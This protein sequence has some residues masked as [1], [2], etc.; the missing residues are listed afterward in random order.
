MIT[1]AKKKDKNKKIN[2]ITNDLRKYVSKK[3]FD[4]IILL[5]HVINFIRT[6]EDL[7]KAS[8]KFK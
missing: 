8:K 2:F 4:V 1:L 3:K 5:F 7:K 6:K